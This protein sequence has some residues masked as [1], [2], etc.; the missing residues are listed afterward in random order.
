MDS[1]GRRIRALLVV[2]LGFVLVTAPGGAFAEEDAVVPGACLPHGS[3]V[4]T[5]GC[6]PSA[7]SELRDPGTTLPNLVPDAGIMVATPSVEWDPESETFKPTP[8]I[9]YFDTHSMNTGE[10]AL[11]LIADDP[12]NPTASTVAQCVAFSY[13]AVCQERRRIGGFT[14]HAEHAHFHYEDFAGY[15]ARRLTPDGAV[16]YSDAGLISK[17]EKVSFCLIDVGR[18]DENALIVPTY[19]ACNPVRQGI[20]PGWSDIYTMDLPGQSLPLP[21]PDGR[22][23]LVITLDTADRIYESDDTD[24]RVEAIFDLSRDG[25]W[26]KLV[27]RRRPPV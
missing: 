7:T 18:H 3:R 22:Y 11:D 19:A 25:T 17:S 4:V 14:F 16:D 21:V 26:V 1:L 27:E 12:S 15:E 13:D 23:A 2:A 24:N 10:V 8:P 20:S 6:V 9:L 5:P